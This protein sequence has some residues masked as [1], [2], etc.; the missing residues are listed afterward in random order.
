VSFEQK[1]SAVLAMPFVVLGLFAL[2]NTCRF[3]FFRYVFKQRGWRAHLRNMAG[4]IS[5]L[6]VLLF[7]M[8]LYVTKTILSVFEC[9]PTSP[10]DGKFY[11][12]AVFEECGKPG[13]VQLRLI[14]WAVL[15]IITIVLGYPAFVLTMLLRHRETAMEDQLLR[16][17]DMSSPQA[18]WTALFRAM[19]GRSYYQFKPDY[20]WWLI[21][22][23]TRK[24]FIAFSSLMFNRNPAFQ[25]A[26]CL[27][28]L[29]LAYAM[30]V[31]YR[32]YM[33]A[34]EF[35]EVLEYSNRMAR[36]NPHGLYNRLRQRL[37]T[38]DAQSK[39]RTTS[40]TLAAGSGARI[41]AAVL[42]GHMY[43]FLT[44][45]NTL[46]A[47]LLFSASLVTLMGV[48]YQ[49]ATPALSGFD[50]AYYASARESITFFLMLLV[51]VSITYYI[52]VLLSDLTVRPRSQGQPGCRLLAAC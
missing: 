14:P 31:R 52:A 23:L 39:K 50:E 20:V 10:P 24:F 16:A 2:Y 33:P 36:K 32:P 18:S 42:L 7:L 38:V 47:C 11:L 22:V 28:V 21:L 27:L 4:S 45:Y 35:D 1:F 34:S 8:Y 30:Q 17:L 49:S 37:L 29:F 6:L 12:Q 44:N 9:Q 48:M 13:G 26:F 40:N 41:S 19:M 25:M 51:A 43:V 3:L 46:E 5:V 15:G